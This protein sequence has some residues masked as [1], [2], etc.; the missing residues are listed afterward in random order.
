MSRRA[1]VISLILAFGLSVLALFAMRGRSIQPAAGATGS[2]LLSFPPAEVTEIRVHRP[3]ADRV[4]VVRR[5]TEGRWSFVYESAEGATSPWPVV[6]ARP[7]ALLGVLARIRTETDDARRAVISNHALRVELLSSGGARAELLIDPAPIAG[8]TLLQIDGDTR[9]FVDE[10][11]YEALTAPGP[12]GWR[13]LSA[14]PAAGPTVSRFSIAQ[15]DRSLAFSRRGEQ[16][17]LTM[18][19]R[20]RAE[21]AAVRALLDAAS[22]LS[23]QRFLDEKT[24]AEIFD[25]DSIT[26]IIMEADERIVVD[27]E[28]SPGDADSRSETR[29]QVRRSG[30]QIGALASLDTLARYAAPIDTDQVFIVSQTPLAQA[31]LDATLFVA[32][33]TANSVPADV[34]MIAILPDELVGGEE[35]RFRREAEGW[36]ALDP[37]SVGKDGSA[38]AGAE[39][40]I[41]AV[42]ELLSFLTAP[43]AS[44]IAFTAPD[45]FTPIASI[46]LFDFQGGPLEEITIGQRADGSVATVVRDIPGA[47]QLV[48]RSYSDADL[49]T[50]L[51][52]H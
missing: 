30:L 46:T 12:P 42:G 13:S 33:S 6:A 27:S 38:D 22:E 52:S 7:R 44:A 21:A 50:L 8:K 18:P 43:A 32:R 31:N 34:G 2:Q 23:V 40:T 19:V 20:A 26:T 48:Y 10:P 15:R 5:E 28:G 11:L 16:W 35:R 39:G 14:L 29:I 17:T 47:D 37:A 9:T 41:A 3:G 25:D 4:E 36:R 49:S 1:L 45:G 51:V 24:A